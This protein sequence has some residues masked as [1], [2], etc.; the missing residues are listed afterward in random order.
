M[1]HQATQ[2]YK[3]LKHDGFTLKM[4][5]HALITCERSLFER[6]GNRHQQLR[7]LFDQLKQFDDRVS[8]LF[9]KDVNYYNLFDVSIL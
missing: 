6:N 4:L 8:S 9:Q 2:T 3:K 7:L 1:S 5:E